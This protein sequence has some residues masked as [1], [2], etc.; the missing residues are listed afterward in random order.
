MGVQVGSCSSEV[1]GLEANGV[2]EEAAGADGDLG[3]VGRPRDGVVFGL[4]K[5]VGTDILV[6]LSEGSVEVCDF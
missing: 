4:T 3:E 2:N 6:V 1:C 5:A